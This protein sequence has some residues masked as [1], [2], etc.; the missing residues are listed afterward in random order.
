MIQQISM[1]ISSTNAHLQVFL[2]WPFAEEECNGCSLL[3]EQISNFICIFNVNHE[4]GKVPAN[5]TLKPQ[6]IYNTTLHPSGICNFHDLKWRLPNWYF[7][8]L[9]GCKMN[10]ISQISSHKMQ[11]VTK[12]WQQTPGTL[13][14]NGLKWVNGCGLGLQDWKT[15]D[16]IKGVS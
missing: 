6:N 9:K 1:I 16:I 13:I 14:W 3:P 7:R 5:K 4:R 12:I 2:M 15:N 11:K 10:F 8:H